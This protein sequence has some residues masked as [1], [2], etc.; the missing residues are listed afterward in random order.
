[1]QRNLIIAA[2]IFGGLLVGALTFI[3]IRKIVMFYTPNFILFRA[4]LMLPMLGF[5]TIM[6]IFRLKNVNVIAAIKISG[7]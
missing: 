2:A 6:D 3:D 4:W 5:V 7:S 1:M